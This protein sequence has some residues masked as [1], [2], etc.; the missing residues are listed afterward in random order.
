M[1]PVLTLL[2]AE[3]IHTLRESLKEARQEHQT[4]EGQV[5][6]L[7]S[8][9]TANKVIITHA[10]LSSTGLTCS[11]VQSGHA[12]SATAASPS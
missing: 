7:R 10:T 6:E 5:R 8:A 4:L 2:V 1:S 12:L 3:E 9:E 11:T